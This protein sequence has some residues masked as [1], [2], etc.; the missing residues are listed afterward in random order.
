MKILYSSH[1]EDENTTKNMVGVLTPKTRGL[2]FELLKYVFTRNLPRT[3]FHCTVCLSL[4]NCTRL[5][6]I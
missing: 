2:P 1:D 5:A 6:H 3:R 4:E